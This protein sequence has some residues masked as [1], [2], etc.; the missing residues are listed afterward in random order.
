MIFSC[1]KKIIIVINYDTLLGLSLDHVKMYGH[2]LPSNPSGRRRITPF[3]TNSPSLIGTA[4][5]APS[6]NSPVSSFENE[7]FFT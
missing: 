6:N 5:K 1:C 2:V 7:D 4:A 3:S